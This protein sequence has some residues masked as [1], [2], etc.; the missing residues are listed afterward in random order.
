M[1]ARLRSEH[2][3][4]MNSNGSVENSTSS[5]NLFDISFIFRPQPNL[6][7]QIYKYGFPVS[8]L[9]GFIDNLLSL[10][11]FS[12]PALRTVSTGCL[13]IFL[14]ISDTFYLI[15]C[16]IS[17]V[18]FGLLQPIAPEYY[19]QLCRFRAFIQSTTQLFSAWVL[20]TI[21]FDRW[22][23]TRFPFKAVIW[24][25]PKRALLLTV[26]LLV[27]CIG[28][29]SHQLSASFGEFIPGVPHVCSASITSI[30]YFIFY[31]TEWGIIVVGSKNP[32]VSPLPLQ[33]TIVDSNQ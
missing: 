15:I 14:A 17:F 5:S 25:T 19:A 2:F 12:R 13:F 21:S 1:S 3:Y 18:E 32:N 8:F 33:Q 28:L 11:T 6:A 20:V 22:F 4:T 16:A 27:V 23:R 7:V 26:L 30:T 31:Y 9:L 10:L 29:N 24:C